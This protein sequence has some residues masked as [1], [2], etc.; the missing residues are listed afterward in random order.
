MS[1]AFTCLN[2]ASQPQHIIR[3]LPK[4]VHSGQRLSLVH[5]QIINFRGHLPPIFAIHPLPGLRLS[6]VARHLVP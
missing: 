2:S 5:Q 1:S 6:F 4:S 3:N